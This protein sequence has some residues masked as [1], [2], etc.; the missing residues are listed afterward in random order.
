MKKFTQIYTMC[1]HM[2]NMKQKENYKKIET[3]KVHT[4]IHTVSVRTAIY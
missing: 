2:N 3:L 4:D 1:E